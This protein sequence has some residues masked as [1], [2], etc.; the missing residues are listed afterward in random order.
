MEWSVVFD[1]KVEYK[2]EIYSIIHL[3]LPK[4][5]VSMVREY[6]SQNVFV[7]YEL[8]C[9]YEGK[10]IC[11]ECFSCDIEDG[12]RT[13]CSIVRYKRRRRESSIIEF[14][15]RMSVNHCEAYIE[16]VLPS[17]IKQTITDVIKTGKIRYYHSR[18]IGGLYYVFEQSIDEIIV[19]FK[20]ICAIIATRETVPFCH[21]RYM[22]RF[23]HPISLRYS[24]RAR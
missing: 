15:K 10:K 19:L 24:G 5:L 23:E 18:A 21:G 9:I 12:T 3:Y 16:T 17:D 6:F 11:Y 20:R 2:E 14:C 4:D 1:A 7:K 22:I 13:P 8:R